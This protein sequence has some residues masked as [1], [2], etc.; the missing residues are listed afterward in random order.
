MIDIA[1]QL[2][3]I[4]REVGERDGGESVAVLLRRSYAAEPEDVW[5][6]ITDPERIRRW[7]M[8]ISGDLRVGGSFQLEGNAGGEILHC[9]PPELLRVTFGGPTSIVELRLRAEGEETVLELEHTVPRTIARSVAGAL[10]VGP[11]WDGALMALDLY[12]HAQQPDDPV[13]AAASREAQEFGRDSI[14]AWTA[15]VVADGSVAEAEVAAVAA[16][17][18]AQFAP[19]V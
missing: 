12:V 14:E 16:A 8:P 5:D 6:A 9:E 13:A 19:D 11:G 18:R 15:V 3:A 17:S 4:Y 10:F 1:G 2:A 7:F